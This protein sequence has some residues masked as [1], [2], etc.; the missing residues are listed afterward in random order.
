MNHIQ[1]CYHLR[2]PPTEPAPSDFGINAKPHL[3]II[4]EEIIRHIPDAP[5]KT[6]FGA[7]LR[8]TNRLWSGLT[9]F[10]G[11]PRIPLDNNPVE[12]G[13]RPIALR[14]K[15]SLFAASEAGAHAAA[16]LA[17]IFESCK[18]SKV[19]PRRYL[20]NTIRDLH[21][22]STEFA[23]LRPAAYGQTRQSSVA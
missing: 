11:D 9:A 16:V 5:P 13:M 2:G 4:A 7:A 19:E 18:R 10:L 23:E 15:N 1:Q 20:T 12:R 21:A 17:T 14:R 22:G 8:Y 6:K 3:D